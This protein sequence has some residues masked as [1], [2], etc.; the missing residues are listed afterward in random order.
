MTNNTKKLF[1]P[2][3]ESLE[4]KKLGFNEDCIAF[5]NN[6]VEPTFLHELD[7]G[8]TT[9]NS[10]QNLYHSDCTAPLFQ[11]VFDWFDEVHGIIG[12]IVPIH[13]ENNIREYDWECYSKFF[14]DE[15]IQSPPY[16]TNYDA[17]LGCINHIINYLK[18]FK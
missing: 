10:E 12:T 11:Q 1:L 6:H 17:K 13:I 16:Y 4:L 8:K 3:K 5:Y 2:Y 9:K 7:R 14:E 18:E 15:E